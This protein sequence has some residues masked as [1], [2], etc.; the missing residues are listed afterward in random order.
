MPLFH[1]ASI[2]DSYTRILSSSFYQSWI[3]LS[4]TQTNNWEA[5]IKAHTGPWDIQEFYKQN[6]MPAC[7]WPL[8]CCSVIMTV[9]S[10]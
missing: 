8:F 5:T 1:V 10:L 7:V 9:H 4:L 2:S 6:Q 3:N